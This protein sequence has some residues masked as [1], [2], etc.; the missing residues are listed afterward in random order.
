MNKW[1]KATA[2]F[3]CAVLFVQGI[4]QNIVSAESAGDIRK[5]AQIAAKFTVA[6][7]DGFFEEPKDLGMQEGI[8][9]IEYE[10]EE[11]RN[12]I[13]GENTI[14]I[15]YSKK[16]MILG[17]QGYIAKQSNQQEHPI[18]TEI[19]EGKAVFT[20]PETG[21]GILEIEMIADIAMPE[22]KV[23]GQEATEKVPANLPIR[24]K[25]AF[26]I[27]INAVDKEAE[28]R[29]LSVLKKKYTKKN[30]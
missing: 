10:G 22:V 11:V 14:E 5:E 3:L 26:T 17:K 20:C 24:S 1:K 28:S 8:E 30:L 23:N 6:Y 15:K 21:E 4:P 25:E 12:T 7:K 13:Q 18:D 2:C 9:A 19:V 16:M 27:T 29:Q